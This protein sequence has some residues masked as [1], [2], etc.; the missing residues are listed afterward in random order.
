MSSDNVTSITEAKEIVND[1][2]H[3]HIQNNEFCTNETIDK[4]IYRKEDW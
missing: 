2:L 3:S 4:T 1:R